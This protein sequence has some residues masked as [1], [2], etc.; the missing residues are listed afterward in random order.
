MKKCLCIVIIMLICLISTS[1]SNNESDLSRKT[2]S[3][4]VTLDEKQINEIIDSIEFDYGIMSVIDYRYF[5]NELNELYR[6]GIE[7]VP[8]L[9]ERIEN[10]EISSYYKE[11]W[12]R[13][14]YSILRIDENFA[15]VEYW[16]N[17]IFDT[18]KAMLLDS[19]TRIPAIINSN[20]SIEQKID[21]LRNYGLLTIPYIKEMVPNYEKVYMPLFYS[22][23]LHLQTDEWM[24]FYAYRT[25][26]NWYKSDDFMKKTKTFNYFEWINNNWDS[27]V[28]VHTFINDYLLL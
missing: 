12:L 19:R 7:G 1:C 16:K 6:I 25:D 23:G 27:L 22:I 4:Q 17:N 15:G 26:E 3:S 28:K 8:V 9:I 14:I 5:K 21:K 11:F 10:P 20:E 18:F 2:D 13:G 24:E